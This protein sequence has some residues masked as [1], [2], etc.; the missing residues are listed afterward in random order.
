MGRWP[1]LSLIGQEITKMIEPT[2]TESA[3]SSDQPAAKGFFGRLRKGLSKTRDQLATGLGNLLLGEKEINESALEDLETALLTTDVGLETTEAI[4]SELTDRAGRREL[5]NM[6]A[7]YQALHALLVQRLQGVARP[8]SL[9]TRKPDGLPKVIFFVGVNGV[10][11]TTTIGKL[12]KRYKTQG[13]NVMLAAGDT[14]RAA[15]VE[16]LQAWGQREDIPV[17][18]QA[19]GSDSASVAF[20][21]VQS[22]QAKGV[23]VLLVDTAGRLQAKSQLMDEL[24]KIQRVVKRLDPDAPHEVI[25]V[26]DGGVGQ[27]A[28]SQVKLFNETVPL[29]GLVVTKLDGTAKAGVLFALA[30]QSNDAQQVPICFIG[31]GEGVEDLRDFEPE[32][33]VAA[34]LQSDDVA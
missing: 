3:S 18:A 12:A 4:M 32:E 6:G 5:A 19:Q 17:I 10:G 31:V 2:E 23:D 26:L 20:D 24:A 21:A 11:K 22:A 34:L 1:A 16:Q 33:F 29:T 27:N 15:A 8:L 28:L 13:L 7:L 25:L 14:F 9:A 30:T